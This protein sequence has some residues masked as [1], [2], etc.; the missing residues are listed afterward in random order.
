MSETT[1]I[2]SFRDEAINLLK[3]YE[4]IASKNTADALTYLKDKKD[5]SGFTK[6][7]LKSVYKITERIWSSLSS[8]M[9]PSSN[10]RVTRQKCNIHSKDHVR[11]Y[12]SKLAATSIM[13]S[14]LHDLFQRFLQSDPSN[15]M[16]RT[17]FRK[18]LQEA[19]PDRFKKRTEDARCVLCPVSMSF[20]HS[21][22]VYP[23]LII[24]LLMLVDV[25]KLSARLSLPR[26][27]RR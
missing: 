27:L 3:E 8:K 15:K 13:K 18:C 24:Y 14:S 22:V 7:E 19:F 20:S 21:H 17:T 4:E 10:S 16:G 2:R 1:N 6:A 12:L 9:P 11:N 5:N 25:V 26:T 23:Q